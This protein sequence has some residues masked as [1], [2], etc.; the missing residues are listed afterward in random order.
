MSGEKFIFEAEL[1]QKARKPLSQLT[2]KE[3]K[4]RL[5][6][7]LELIASVVENENVDA[8]TISVHTLQIITSELG[9]KKAHNYCRELIAKARSLVQPTTCLLIN[10]FFF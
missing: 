6:L 9:D 10:Q 4:N 7:I 3:H 2:N 5:K 1:S 8:K